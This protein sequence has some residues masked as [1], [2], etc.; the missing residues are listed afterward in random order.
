MPEMVGVSILPP[1]FLFSIFP[2]FL[3][4]N[5]INSIPFIPFNTA[6]VIDSL[7]FFPFIYSTKVL[8]LGGRG[9]SADWLEYCTKKVA[10][11]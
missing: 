6:L 4:F 2:I 7:L 1:Y 11:P 5:L 3:I 9:H 10:K 8:T